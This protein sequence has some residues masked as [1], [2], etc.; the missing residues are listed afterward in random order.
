MKNI[1]SLLFLNFIPTSKDIGLLVLR[2]VFG[3]YMLLAHGWPKL[4]TFS[5][6]S[7]SFPDPFGIGSA[8]SLGSAVAFEVVGS[9]FLIFGLFTR[10][11]ALA[12][13]VVM[14]VA[15]FYVH[16]AVF[17]GDG[18]GELAF[19]YLTAYIVL[20]LS[21]GGRYAVDAKLGGKA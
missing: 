20:F 15:F 9:A 10:F 11:S 7:G 13:I 3:F 18:D 5:Q 4:M 14:G 8:Y 19:V 17:I 12:G 16:K 2:L 21:G 1:F 6:K